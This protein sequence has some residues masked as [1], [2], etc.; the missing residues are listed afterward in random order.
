MCGIFA[1]I[2]PPGQAVDLAACRRAT[3]LMS[4][5]GP[6]ARGEWLSPD[7]EVF[8]GHRRLSILDLSTAANQPMLSPEGDAIVFNGEI[9]N[10]QEVR[11][12]LAAKGHGF[13][14][15]GDTEVLQRAVREWGPDGLAK[16]VGMFA[17]ALWSP[18]QE[19]AVIAR[20]F[21]GQKP[22]YLWRTPQGGLAFASEAK[23]FYA[24]PGFAPELDAEALPEYLRFRSLCGSRTLW[25]GVTRLQP[26][27]A[28]TF[29]RRDGSITPHVFWR[30]ED[31]LPRRRRPPSLEAFDDFF[32]RHVSLHMVSDVPVG[33]QFSGGADSSLVAALVAKRLGHQ[34]TGFH[35]RV[36]DPRLDEWPD[37]LAIGQHLGLPLQK[38]NLDGGVFFGEVL[39]R[40]AWH[41][42]E[43]INHPNC[44]GVYL[45]SR[46]AHGQVKVLLTGEAAD[47]FFAGYARFTKVL[48][49]AWLEPVPPG[50][51]DAGLRAMNFF[52]GLE[53][54][55]ANLRTYKAMG[56][57]E[58]ILTCTQFMDPQSLLA[59]LGSQAPRVSLSARRGL[60]AGWKGLGV[61]DR[62]QLYHLV[63]YLPPIFDRQDKM[64]MAAS[65]E[66]RVPFAT[67]QVLDWALSLPPRQRATL[68][69]QKV[70]LKNYLECYVPR[71]LFARPKVGF[72]IP[73][74]AWFAGAEGRARLDW[75]GSAA[76]P[77]AGLV[78]TILLR[79]ILQKPAPE[80]AEAEY[81]WIM[82]SF[83][84]WADIFLKT[85]GRVLELAP[86]AAS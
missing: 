10:F 67:P 58:A 52:P 30:L 57:D 26:G 41:F 64:S 60:L 14:T 63:T 46:L 24:L 47:E 51:L 9:Y 40:M 59:T 70:F 80:A 32:S 81:L 56:A 82:L 2:N 16:L 6:D 74:Q 8:L 77:L 5:R 69:S 65:I 7:G 1:L 33:L 29:H 71:P 72:S 68:L 17:F 13:R 18:D 3:D 20:D 21:F 43:P 50:V 78:D 83:A 42:D 35:C 48:R 62:A 76:S 85:P 25:R 37:A 61:L 34:L 38:T 79:S 36:D 54:Q 45:T 23:A 19:A 49:H 27:Q 15:T 86:A 4:H 55:A 66:S 28:I 44:L 53:R 39:D 75:L 31:S 84:L 22:A 12:Q 11:A 73:L